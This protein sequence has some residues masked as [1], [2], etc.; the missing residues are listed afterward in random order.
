MIRQSWIRKRIGLWL[1]RGDV[2]IGETG[3][4]VFGPPDAD[5]P[6]DIQWFTQAHYASI[7]CATAAAM[8]ADLALV[9]QAAQK[10]RPRGRT[11]P[12]CSSSSKC[13][14]RK[15]GLVSTALITT[16]G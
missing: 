12:G 1:Q 10:T 6:S 11:I 3:T 9:D 2:L 7:G 5:F 16:Q 13:P 8:G 4:S 14:R 15:P